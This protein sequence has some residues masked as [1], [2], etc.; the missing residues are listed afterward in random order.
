MAARRLIRQ[1][2]THYCRFHLYLSAHSSFI[3][4][5]VKY[6]FFLRFFR[7]NRHARV[8]QPFW[9]ISYMDRIM[10]TDYTLRSETVVMRSMMNNKMHYCHYDVGSPPCGPL[11]FDI[12]KISPKIAYSRRI[13][14]RFFVRRQKRWAINYVL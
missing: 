6:R 2:I 1:L 7:V 13:N 8:M 4:Y 10:Q 12:R 11:P 3:I 5:D 14:R 9:G